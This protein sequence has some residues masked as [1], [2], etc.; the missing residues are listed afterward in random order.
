MKN[1]VFEIDKER[2]CKQ[3]ISWFV[4]CIIMI[5]FRLLFD[6]TE[7]TS[8]NRTMYLDNKSWCCVQNQ[9]ISNLLDIELLRCSFF[10]YP[11]YRFTYTRQ[12]LKILWFYRV[13]WIISQFLRYGD[14]FMNIIELACFAKKNQMAKK[15]FST[16]REKFLC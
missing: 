7:E 12:R 16:K 5:N 3:M 1:A 2:A 15:I 6:Q 10:K 13:W 11:T 14:D 9:D 8:K 4:Y